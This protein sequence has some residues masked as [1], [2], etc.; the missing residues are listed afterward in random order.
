MACSRSPTFPREQAYPEP[1]LAK[2]C[3]VSCSRR[4]NSR[5]HAGRSSHVHSRKHRSGHKPWLALAWKTYSAARNG[6]GRV[7]RATPAQPARFAAGT[8]R[9]SST[10]FPYGTPASLQPLRRQA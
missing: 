7:A 5:P 6:E 3:P 2:V 9:S 1:P 8:S 10:P 4:F